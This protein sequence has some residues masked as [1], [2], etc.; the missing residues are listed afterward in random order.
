M[1][2]AKIQQ[3]KNTITAQTST[4]KFP[5]PYSRISALYGTYTSLKLNNMSALTFL[6]LLKQLL[7]ER[8][9]SF[10]LS[11][12]KGH[13]FKLNNSNS[14]NVLPSSVPKGLYFQHH[15]IKDFGA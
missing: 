11:S 12:Y 1:I 9:S 3:S 14:R 8:P 7:Q 15:S 2:K 5:N 10:F 13:A 6:L 4:S